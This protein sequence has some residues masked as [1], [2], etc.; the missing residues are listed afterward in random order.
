V[1]ILSLWLSTSGQFGTRW[2]FLVFGFLGL[3]PV[4]IRT[5]NNYALE[6]VD[7]PQ[8]PRYLAMLNLAMAGPGVVASLLVGLAI[9]LIGYE[10]TFT[11]VVLFQFVG[12]LLC[13]RLIE[14]RRH[15]AHGVHWPPGN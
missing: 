2:F 13:F 7:R 8:H 1:P 6:L 15:H 3:S 9:D 4:A 10:P 12:Y 11:V 5:F 14:P